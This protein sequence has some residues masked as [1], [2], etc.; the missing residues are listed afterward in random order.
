MSLYEFPAL[1]STSLDT[2]L[3]E[4]SQTVNVLIPS[5][6]M[7]I[8]LVVWISGSLKQRRETGTYD[9]PLWGTIASVITTMIAFF[10]SMKEG[11]MDL[12]T[13]VIT[14][15]VSLLMAIWLFSSKDKV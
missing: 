14:V 4:T 3:V 6:L 8:F 11:L 9:A 13:L 5:F 7:F 2:A 12:P 1:N 10:L 15:S